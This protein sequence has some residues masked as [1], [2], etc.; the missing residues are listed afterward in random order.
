M[1]TY[2][3]ARTSTRTQNI[4]RQIRNILAAEP[5]AKIY[6]EAYTGTKIYGREEFQ[7]LLK[8]VKPGDKII[9]DS[10]SRMSR[11]ADDGVKLY[12]ELFEMGVALEF[13]KE[14]YIDTVV[15]EQNIKDKI[16]YTGTDEDLIFEGLNKY[17]KRLAERQIRIA[18]EQ[19]EKEVKDLHVRTKEGLVTARKSGKQIGQP[20]GTKLVTKKSVEA[21]AGI[22]KYNKTFGGPLNDVETIRQ[23]GISRKSF[24][25]YKKEILENQATGG[26]KNERLES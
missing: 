15:Y 5:N 14:P 10:V 13:I 20:K 6:Q 1:V 8:K 11:S 23:L 18:F 2:G 9:F 16:E 4:E 25:K 3:Y 22:K 7:K 24:Y 12:F 19:S 21:K 26:R 17:F